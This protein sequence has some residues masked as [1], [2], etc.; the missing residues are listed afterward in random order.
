MV[1]PNSNQGIIWDFRIDIITFYSQ[2]S[3]QVQHS[4]SQNLY[5]GHLLQSIKEQEM[6]DS[7][8]SVGLGIL[9]RFK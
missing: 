1:S 7:S 5:P 8:F 9:P 6:G 4:Q 2:I 3:Q